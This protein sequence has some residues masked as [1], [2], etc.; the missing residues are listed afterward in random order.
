[1]EIN[2]SSNQSGVHKSRR[3]PTKRLAVQFSESYAN[4]LKGGKTRPKIDQAK[5]RV[6]S[7]LRNARSLE[8]A[9]ESGKTNLEQG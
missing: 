1:M 2:R 3:Q 8:V 4:L 5:L 7:A 6:K 9:E